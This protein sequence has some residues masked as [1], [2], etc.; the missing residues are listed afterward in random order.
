MNISTIIQK[1]FETNSGFHVKQRHTEKVQFL[2]IS[3]FWLVLKKFSTSTIKG[4]FSKSKKIRDK[5]G[6]SKLKEFIYK[7]AGANIFGHSNC[8]ICKIFGS[9]DQF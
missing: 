3:S 1:I 6:R 5:L 9:G 8:D 7:D 2:F 4:S